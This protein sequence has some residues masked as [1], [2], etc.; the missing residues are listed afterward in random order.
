MKE[1]YIYIVKEYDFECGGIISIHET[2]KGAYKFYRQKKIDSY[3]SW[4]EERTKYGKDRFEV[5]V[6]IEKRYYIEK[7][8]IKP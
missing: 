3:N 8:I 4:F 5:G 7:Q 1:K 6:F 2:L